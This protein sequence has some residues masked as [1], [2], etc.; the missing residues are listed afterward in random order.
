MIVNNISFSGSYAKTPHGNYYKKKNTGIRIG[1]M[2][3]LAGGVG[4]AA[5]PTVQLGALGISA[6]IFPKSPMKMFASTYGII[7][8]GILGIALIG[9]ALG[10]IPDH[11]INRKRISKADHI[12]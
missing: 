12:A 3:G 11:A 1:T 2:L 8:A 6:Q 4:L 10:S 5:M 9:R 7:G